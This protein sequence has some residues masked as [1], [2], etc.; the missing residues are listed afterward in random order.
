MSTERKLPPDLRLLCLDVD[1]VLTDGGI[2][3]DDHGIET[4]RFH[5]RDGTG[6][7]IWQ[8]L[9]FEICVVTGRQG[10]A[11]RHRMN[12]LGVRHILQGQQ[13]K[14]PGF[15]TLL[16]KLDLDPQQAAVL[17]DDL[18]DLPM[19]RRCG[20]PMAVADASPEVRDAAHFT[21]LRPGGHAAVRE[22]IE[23]LVKGLGRWNEA[24]ELYG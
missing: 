6:I 14:L 2:H 3:L 8:R 12:E 22:A 16:K 17:G 19:M 1:G 18:P 10:V 9:G 11:V 5:V 20:Y 7:R 4:K 21:T 13:D 23:H 15:M 24:L